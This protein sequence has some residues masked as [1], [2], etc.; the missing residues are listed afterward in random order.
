MANIHNLYYFYQIQ[1]ILDMCYTFI[2][3]VTVSLS[4]SNYI[5]HNNQMKISVLAHKYLNNANILL[6]NG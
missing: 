1:P 3:K 4:Y 6:I 2:N 5:L